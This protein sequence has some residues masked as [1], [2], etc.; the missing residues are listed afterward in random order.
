MNNE[1]ITKLV[2]QYKQQYNILAK[3]LEDVVSENNY[4]HQQKAA[5]QS[6]SVQPTV[7]KPHNDF[8]ASQLLETEQNLVNER[9]HVVKSVA[10][11]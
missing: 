6:H 1:E 4:L 8:L 11:V 3:R 5:A 9:Q 10:Q 2:S 7:P